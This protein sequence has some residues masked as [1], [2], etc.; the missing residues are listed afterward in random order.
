MKLNNKE[1]KE[2]SKFRRNSLKEANKSL[3]AILIYKCDFVVRQ[4][5]LPVPSEI[6]E[7]DRKALQHRTPARFVTLWKRMKIKVHLDGEKA[8]DLLLWQNAEPANVK[9]Q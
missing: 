1:V 5:E 4:E 9:G 3:K 2:A 8:N 6:Q 7:I